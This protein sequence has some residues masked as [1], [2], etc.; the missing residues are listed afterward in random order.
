MLSC[1]HATRLIS[2]GLDRS[3]SWAERLCLGVHLLLCVPCL[4]FRR[5]AHWLHRA[6]ASP[7]AD[8]RLP[9]AAR[10]RIQRALE[11]A[12]RDD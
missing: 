6:L 11:Q 12:A 5:A 10:A 4:R 2:D 7:P 3:L 1:R 9:P 8:I